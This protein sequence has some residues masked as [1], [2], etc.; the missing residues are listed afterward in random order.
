MIALPFI[1][2][3]FLFLVYAIV[4]GFT[5]GGDVPQIPAIT[6]QCFGLASLSVIYGLVMAALNFGGALGPILAGH[7]FDVTG[8]YTTVFLGIAGGLFVAAFCIAK[9]RPRY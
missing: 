2:S 3:D 7:V 8:S 1:G 5:Y 4:F 9:L 6:A